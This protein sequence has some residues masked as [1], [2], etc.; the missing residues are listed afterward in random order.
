MA[1]ETTKGPLNCASITR[2]SVHKLLKNKAFVLSASANVV[3][4]FGDLTANI[5]GIKHAIDNIWEISFSSCRAL[6][7]TNVKNSTTVLSTLHKFCV[8][9]H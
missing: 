2:T 4:C 3:F 7:S 9:L 8:M 5:F 6:W 1:L